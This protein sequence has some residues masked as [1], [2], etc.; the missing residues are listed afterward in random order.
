VPTGTLPAA[1]LDE[2][3]MPLAKSSTA[4]SDWTFPFSGIPPRLTLLA[5]LAAK[6]S[7]FDIGINQEGKTSGSLRRRAGHHGR[8]LAVERARAL[9]ERISTYRDGSQYSHGPDQC[10]HVATCPLMLNM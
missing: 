9:R 7:I 6:N 3:T 5:F 2:G 4:P 1:N 10:T 8:P